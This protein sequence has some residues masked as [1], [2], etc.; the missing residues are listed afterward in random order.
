MPTVAIIV[1]GI[2]V[3]GAVTYILWYASIGGGNP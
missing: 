2:A 1:L 3:V